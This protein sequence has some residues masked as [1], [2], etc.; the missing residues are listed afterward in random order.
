[1]NA[2]RSKTTTKIL[3]ILLVLAM[4]MVARESAQF[5]STLE[6][7]ARGHFKK[8]GRRLQLWWTPDMEGLIQE[9]LV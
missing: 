2:D 5:V 3:A 4:I 6:E 9:R 1:M 8:M 7:H